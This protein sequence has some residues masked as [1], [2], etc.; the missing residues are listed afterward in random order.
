M[1]KDSAPAR[2][3]APATIA[4]ALAALLLAATVAVALLRSE[5]PDE[6]PAADPAAARPGTPAEAIAAL[7]TGLRQ[8]PD[9]DRGWFMLGM[10]YRES[11]QFGEAA[12]A[13]RR[14]GELSPRNADYAAYLG[15]VLLL[16]GGEAA[17]PEAGRLFRRALELEPGNPQAR[18]YL[19]T[20]RDRGGD[21]RG[22]IDDLVALL[23]EAPAGAPWAPQVRDAAEAIAREHHIDLAGR[24]PAPAPSTATAAIPGPSPA[25]MEAARGMSPSQQD[26]MVRAMVDGLAARLRQNPRDADGW[27]R[28]MRSRMVLRDPAAAGAALRAG[29][30]A[31]PGDAA[32]Q[33]RLRGAARELGI[34]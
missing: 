7:R 15:E 11:G 4:L 29:L 5:V 14:A 21:H 22:A 20:L 9:N 18:Y 28:L 32:T 30:A 12:Q 13:F 34:P 8:D 16:A 1:A 2:R 27:I 3:I 31:F 26:A 33:A 6:A 24:L 10:T 17:A 23:R 19:A 25:Q